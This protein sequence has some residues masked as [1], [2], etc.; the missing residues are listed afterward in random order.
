[1]LRVFLSVLVWGAALLHTYAL[2]FS[3]K[4]I[5]SVSNIC[6]LSCIASLTNHRL[7]LFQTFP[8]VFWRWPPLPRPQSRPQ[9]SPTVPTSQSTAAS[10]S[11][12]TCAPSRSTKSS[13]ATRAPERSRSSAEQGLVRYFFSTRGCEKTF[14]LSWARTYHQNDHIIT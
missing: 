8:S 14:T 7:L 9:R 12:S 13:A 4:R 11:P 1:M 6:F 3:S 10:S 5:L 2:T